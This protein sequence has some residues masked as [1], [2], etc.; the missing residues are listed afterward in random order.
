[1]K[2]KLFISQLKKRNLKEQGE[3]VENIVNFAKYTVHWQN[4][5]AVPQEVFDSHFSDFSEEDRILAFINPISLNI[6]F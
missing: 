4:Q 6:T 3:C 1:M 5:I 2:L